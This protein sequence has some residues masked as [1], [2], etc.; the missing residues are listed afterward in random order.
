MMK[1]L[2]MIAMAALLAA[3]ATSCGGGKGQ[4]HR[5]A[6]PDTLRA[7]FVPAYDSLPGTWLLPPKTPA[8]TT[9]RRGLE[10]KADSTART[11][12]LPLV[13]CT[14]W[15][16]T[17]DG[18]QLVLTLTMKRT[19][20]DTAAVTLQDTCAFSI[21]ADTLRLSSRLTGGQ[22]A[23]LTRQGAKA[24]AAPAQKKSLKISK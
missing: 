20:A 8:D 6:A 21:G 22:W 4:D 14:K 24:A 19:P 3:S 16:L 13:S 18:K 1:K 12:G 15:K 9:T 11:L 17:K 23:T 7:T 2:T 5:A 10:L